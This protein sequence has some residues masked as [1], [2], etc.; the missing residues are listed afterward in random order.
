[1]TFL[2]QNNVVLI[3]NYS[4]HSFRKHGMD[5]GPLGLNMA[6]VIN[7]DGIYVAVY[8]GLLLNLKLIRIGHYESPGQLPLTK[9]SIE[10]LDL[11]LTLSAQINHF[12]YDVII[13]I[14]AHNIASVCVY[15][16]HK[17]QTGNAA[18]CLIK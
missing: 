16:C 5:D 10:E 8:F 7:A 6:P 11:I 14:P 18:C 12:Q 13:Q 4:G 1:M 9:V 17:S 2:S 3:F 15:A